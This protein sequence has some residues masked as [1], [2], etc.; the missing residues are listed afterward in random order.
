MKNGIFVID[1]KYTGPFKLTDQMNDHLSVVGTSFPVRSGCGSRT[2]QWTV[3][4][5]IENPEFIAFHVSE[6]HSLVV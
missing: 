4:N 1:G 6:I 2:S 5:R 3:T